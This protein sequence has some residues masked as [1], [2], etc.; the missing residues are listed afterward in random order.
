MAYIAFLQSSRV[1]FH[2]QVTTLYFPRFRTCCATGPELKRRVE[3]IEHSAPS[4]DFALQVR[5]YSGVDAGSRR[6]RRVACRKCWHPSDSLRFVSS[7]SADKTPGKIG[8]RCQERSA[9]MLR[10]GPLH[11]RPLGLS[12]SRVNTF[13]N[14]CRRPLHNVRSWIISV[15]P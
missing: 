8:T 13:V 15:T 2:R 4:P 12:T 5:Q 11:K 9:R 1:F 10:R 6:Q 3:M 7:T 14:H